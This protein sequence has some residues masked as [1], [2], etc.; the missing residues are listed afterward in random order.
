M[1]S[2]RKSLIFLCPAISAACLAA[3]YAVTGQGIAAVMALLTL[4]LGLLAR[5]RPATVPPSAALAASVSIAA[6]GLL[7]RAPSVLMILGA[8]LALASWDLVLW[9]QTLTDNSISSAQTIALLE[10]RHYQS[11]ALAL[12]P[13]LLIAITGP[14]IRVQLPFMG[15]VL[16]VILALFSLDRVWR[17][18]KD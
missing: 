18:L 15:L 5:K 2:V 3:G 1:L 7:T 6:A 11:L 13:G 12:A 8:A 17:T 14:L 10:T 4:P 16:L 9:E